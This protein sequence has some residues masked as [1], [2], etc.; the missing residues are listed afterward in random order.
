[1]N[2]YV[3]G[4]TQA[5]ENTKLS[6]VFILGFAVPSDYGLDVKIGWLSR[7]NLFFLLSFLSPFQAHYW[8]HVGITF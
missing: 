4:K 3:K 8:E 6:G 7:L 5:S 2:N 1:M